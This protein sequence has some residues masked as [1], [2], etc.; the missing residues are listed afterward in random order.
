SDVCSSDLPGG[1]LG[2]EDGFQADEGVDAF[3]GELAAVAALFDATEGEAGVGGDHGV[4]EGLAGFEL[5]DET[6]LLGAVSGPHAAAEA[7]R[8]PVG[9]GDGLVEVVGAKEE[10]D[11]A[12][13]FFVGGGSAFRNLRENAGAEP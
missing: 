12:E 6:A 7:E 8:A 2:D 4:D 5:V 9:E 1:A 13:D 11:G 10:G 3:G